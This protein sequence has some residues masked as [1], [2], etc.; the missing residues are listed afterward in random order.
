M[1]LGRLPEVTGGAQTLAGT[2]IGRFGEKR[3][4]SC[5]VLPH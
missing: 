3:A 2:L 5:S 4:R 1:M